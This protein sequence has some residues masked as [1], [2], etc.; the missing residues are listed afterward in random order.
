MKFRIKDEDGKDYEVEEI[1]EKKSE[2]DAEE[3]G[4]VE[5]VELSEDEIKALKTLA[6][7]ANDLLA[8]L[9]STTQTDEEEEEEKV[10]DE[11]EDEEEVMDADEEVVETCE[12]KTTHDSKSAFGSLSSKKYRVDDSLED[13][14]SAAWAKRYGGNR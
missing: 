11:D 10:E 1:L 14:V 13:E 12:E 9:D 3:V 7:K 5:K 4:T 2:E 6:A 8:L